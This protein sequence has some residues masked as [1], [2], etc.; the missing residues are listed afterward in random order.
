MKQVA[1]LV[2]IDA[3]KNYLLMHR[4]AHP[5]FRNDPDLPGG[6]LEGNEQPLRTMIREVFEEAGIVVAESDVNM[7]YQGTE[8]SA[9]GT[10]YSL[11]VTTVV[12]RPV[13]TISWEHSAYEWLNRA[14]FYQQQRMRRTPTCVWFMTT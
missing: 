4:S 12:I 2:V 14:D 10:Q 9:H 5:T 13:V 1:K 3:D 7:I 6:T 8:Y 11:F